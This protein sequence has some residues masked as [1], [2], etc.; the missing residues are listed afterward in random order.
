M[1][2][3]RATETHV[4]VYY[5]RPCV[6]G[7]YSCAL[8]DRALRGAVASFKAYGVCYTKS[9]PLYRWPDVAAE[10]PRR[11][12]FCVDI[13]PDAETL[14]I[15]ARVADEVTIIDHHA[16]AEERLHGVLP[17]NVC[18]V[19]DTGGDH[20][21]ASLVL[22]YV[23][24]PEHN[25]TGFD[26][27]QQSIVARVEHVRR[28]DLW[29]FEL[30]DATDDFNQGV[31][32]LFERGWVDVGEPEMAAKVLDTPIT[33]L[34][35]RGNERNKHCYSLMK[36]QVARCAET[37]YIPT[38]D[39]MV[40]EVFAVDS[41]NVKDN[42]RLAQMAADASGSKITAVITK[43]YDQPVVSFSIRSAT[44]DVRTQIAEFHDSKGGGHPHACGFRVPFDLFSKWR[45]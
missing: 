19:I 35:K 28:F 10:N 40:A 21:G 38:R 13:A 25:M 4:V 18:T 32:S 41:G 36:E 29:K 42:S 5:H 26:F 24:Q 45:N 43:I 44:V 37:L 9:W 17:S 3:A 8:L 31:V 11:L 15:L 33:E 27:T 1:K 30:R 7:A 14:K 22:R 16:T 34:L 12:V 20:S 23:Q 39:G 2:R 6:D